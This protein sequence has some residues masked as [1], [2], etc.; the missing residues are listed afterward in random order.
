[1]FSNENP[2]G[3]EI[4]GFQPPHA[5]VLFSFYFVYKRHTLDIDEPKT[6]RNHTTAVG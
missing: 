4:A 5:V 3:L 1:M 2:W 6:T